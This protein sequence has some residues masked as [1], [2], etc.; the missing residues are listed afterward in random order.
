MART[1]SILA[2]AELAMTNEER[3]SMYYAKLGKKKC[4]NEVRRHYS[5]V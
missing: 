5:D 2:E 3:R 4:R 1:I